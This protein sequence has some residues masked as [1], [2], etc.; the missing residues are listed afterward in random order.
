MF[1]DFSEEVYTFFLS[2]FIFAVKLKKKVSVLSLLLVKVIL[3]F[4]R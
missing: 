2:Y 1:T 4:S 3:S